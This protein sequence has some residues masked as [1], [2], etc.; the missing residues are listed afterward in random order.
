M[1]HRILGI[2]LLVLTVGELPLHAARASEGILWDSWGIPHIYAKTETALFRAFGWAQAHSHGPM[3]MRLYAG[4]RARSAALLGADHAPSDRWML[5]NGVPDRARRWYDA[6]SPEFRRN[7]DAFAEGINAYCHRYPEN[8]PPH[9]REVLP[10]SGND[11][12]AHAH[13]VVHYFYLANESVVRHVSTGSNQAGSNA[14]AV[15]PGRS[16]SGSALLL[17]NPHMPW[18]EPFVLYEAGLSGP[19][20]DA[21]GVAIVGSP[22]LS[23]GFNRHLGWT[24]TVNTID[25]Y[26]LYELTLRGQGYVFD[27]VEQS[28]E[29]EQA[30][31]PIKTSSGV[32]TERLEIRRS[33]HGPVIRTSGD[34]AFALRVSGLDQP[35]LL[36]Q[37]WQMMRAQNLGQ[38]ESAIRRMQIPLFTII[39]ADRK[40]HILHWYGGQ[41][42]VRPQGPW[43]WNDIVPGDT[44]ASLWRETSPYRELPRLLDPK[45]GWLQNSNDAPWTTTFPQELRADQFAAYVPSP[46]MDLRAQAAVNGI[47]AVEKVSLENLMEL[48]HSTRV[49]MA[50]RILPDLL[51]SVSS[52]DLPIVREA[53]QVLAA[54]DRRVDAE[55]KGSVLFTHFLQAWRRIAGPSPYAQPWSNQSPLSTPSGIREQGKALQALAIAAESVRKQFGELNVAWG[56]VNHFGALAGNGA[57]GELGVLRVV[58][59]TPG[60]QG[61]AYAGDCFVAAVEF[62]KR[63]RAFG[64]LGYGNSSISGSPHRTD[65]LPLMAQK[66]LRPIWFERKEVL[67][68]LEKQDPLP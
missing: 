68:H 41:S 26:D 53:A 60:P 18:V 34:R 56:N 67:E 25:A 44:S 62:S 21:Y 55:S 31:L 64:L 63:I 12:V 14:W 2:A 11:V 5:I 1:R 42:P 13:R 27:G 46:P 19:G 37:Y 45:S 38:F 20:M 8:I 39:Y 66:R 50:D 9:L 24:H 28:F 57:P 51:Q 36:E 61:R 49:V 3:L 22:V 32:I 15:S 17:A 40:G 59:F 54:W 35:Y 29:I 10:I 7:I 23:M 43:K 48:K 52:S 65:Q 47:R 33:V 6:Q 16:A 4:S 58:G 30:S